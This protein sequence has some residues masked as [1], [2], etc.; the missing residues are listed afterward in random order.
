MA[1]VFRSRLL[2]DRDLIS[3]KPV[4]RS[5]QRHRLQ[6]AG[7]LSQTFPE[8]SVHVPVRTAKRLLPE[9]IIK[10]DGAA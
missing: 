10:V 7:R 4:S 1:K 2:R 6:P 8:T 3:S 9:L 5:G